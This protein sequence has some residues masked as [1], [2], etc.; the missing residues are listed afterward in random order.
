MCQR[1]KNSA[2]INGCVGALAGGLHS[3]SSSFLILLIYRPPEFT[4]PR[5]NCNCPKFLPPQKHFLKPHCNCTMA[6]LSPPT[7]TLKAK[8]EQLQL[9]PLKYPPP[10]AEG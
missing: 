1:P 8:A 5:K 7:Y 4:A 2:C 10:H 3:H 9:T 6:I